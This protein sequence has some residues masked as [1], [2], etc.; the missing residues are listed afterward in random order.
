MGYGK[1][2]LE[3]RAST[4]TDQASTPFGP[5]CRDSA[6]TQPWRPGQIRPTR[7]PAT[8][9]H[10]TG[11]RLGLPVPPERTTWCV[12]PGRTDVGD[13]SV[14]LGGKRGCDGGMDM[15]VMG[16]AVQQHH[17]RSFAEL[18]VA[19]VKSGGLDQPERRQRHHAIAVHALVD[20]STRILST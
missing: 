19:E 3:V 4:G 14:A 17:G 20:A 11:R 15:D 12:V 6:R 16:K 13:D 1:R 5:Q 2:Q 18:V 7:R 8:P 10:P 9:A